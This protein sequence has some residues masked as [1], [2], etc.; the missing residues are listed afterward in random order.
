MSLPGVKIKKLKSCYFYAKV[1]KVQI[2]EHST[3]NY[4]QIAWCFLEQSFWIKV[5]RSDEPGPHFFQRLQVRCRSVI[6]EWQRS[7]PQ[8]REHSDGIWCRRQGRRVQPCP[9]PS[10]PW[11][12]ST[13]LTIVGLFDLHWPR[14]RACS[15]ASRR[16]RQSRRWWRLFHCCFDWLSPRFWWH[17]PAEGEGRCSQ[18]RTFQAPIAWF[19]LRNDAYFRGHLFL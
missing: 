5:V 4:I 15:Q 7:S 2:Y 11:W 8:G 10:W 13:G 18:C 3:T 9:Y 19:R 12:G 16:F 6:H 14:Q 17:S 1:T